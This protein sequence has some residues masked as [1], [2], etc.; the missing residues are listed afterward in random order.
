MGKRESEA[1]ESP[2]NGGARKSRTETVTPTV[3]TEWGKEFYLLHA[4]GR[5]VD[6]HG[7][8]PDILAVHLLHSAEP[9][10]LDPLPLWPP[11]GARTL[12]SQSHT[13]RVKAWALLWPGAT[14]ASGDSG[15]LAYRLEE[16]DGW[17]DDADLY[18]RGI[19]Q[20]RQRRQLSLG[21]AVG[22]AAVT[23]AGSIDGCEIPARHV[24]SSETRTRQTARGAYSF[25][26]IFLGNY[27]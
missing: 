3:R 13:E 11:A 21:S 15:R 10:L 25:Y 4:G 1:S 24:R 26:P 5:E 8:D 18:V 17:V 23:S 20:P 2:R 14:P 19:F 27:K 7:E 22:A 16:E 6:V 12:H 9:S